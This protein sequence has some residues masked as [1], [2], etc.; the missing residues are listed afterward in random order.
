MKVRRGERQNQ[1]IELAKAKGSI[2]SADVVEGLGIT[3]NHATVTLQAMT[4]SGK[5]KRSGAV[6]SYT[7][8][9]A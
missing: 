9:A 5:L 4:K 2:K 6:R 7:Y 1:I 3:P 8:E